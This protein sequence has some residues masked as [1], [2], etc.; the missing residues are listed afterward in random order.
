MYTTVSVQSV[1]LQNSDYGAHDD[2]VCLFHRAAE[3][4]VADFILPRRLLSIRDE[5]LLCANEDT[6]IPISRKLMNIIM[7]RCLL[8]IIK[9][10]EVSLVSPH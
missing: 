5:R 3:L 7:K 2:V 1:S 8:K 6:E 9:D 10:C 4:S